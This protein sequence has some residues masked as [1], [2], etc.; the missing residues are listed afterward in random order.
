ME[1]VIV[2]MLFGLIMAIAWVRV[3][4]PD[5]AMAEAAI[6]SGV[7]GA[8]LLATLR[9]LGKRLRPDRPTR[10]LLNALAAGGCISIALMLSFILYQ[11]WGSPEGL[12][13]EVYT[14]LHRSGVENPV[15][16]VIL[17]FRAYDTLLEIAVLLIA[18]LG[19][20][21]LNLHSSNLKVANEGWP[22]VDFYVRWLRSF[23][24]LAM[25]YIVWVGYKWPG[26][27][28]QAG[29]LLGGLGTILL[30]SGRSVPLKWRMPLVR[31]TVCLGLLVFTLAAT[32]LLM[33][34][35]ILQYPP[36]QAKHW[37]LLIELACTLSIGA[38]L[39]ALFAGCAGLLSAKKEET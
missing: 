20:Y 37:I 23:I 19:A 27:A 32:F 6:G 31:W 39:T 1:A 11:T 5:L 12:T 10:P 35:S 4:A 25:V 28:F 9:R 7:T 26:G 15:T 24:L 18:V 16:A 36:G 8:M 13:Q 2:F 33:Q 21:S 3:D 29:A 34:G 22:V 14:E 17:N 38:T 30:L